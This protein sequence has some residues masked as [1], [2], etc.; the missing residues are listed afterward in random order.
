MT[1]DIFDDP[2]FKKLVKKCKGDYQAALERYLTRASEVA[3]FN[4][5]EIEE[6]GDSG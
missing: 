6:L 4:N 2:G 1:T 3:T 5:E